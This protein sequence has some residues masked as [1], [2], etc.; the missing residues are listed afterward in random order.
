[1]NVGK[2]TDRDL[3]IGQLRNRT[4]S[5]T[6]PQVPSLIR[7]LD[8]YIPWWSSFNWS[9]PPQKPKLQSQNHDSAVRLRPAPI[10]QSSKGIRKMNKLHPL[11]QSVRVLRYKLDIRDYYQKGIPWPSLSKPLQSKKNARFTAS[12]RKVSQCQFTWHPLVPQ[13]K[14]VNDSNAQEVLERDPHTQITTTEMSDRA[15]N[16]S[17]RQALMAYIWA[18]RSFIGSTDLSS[19]MNPDFTVMIEDAFALMAQALNGVNDEEPSV[20]HSDNKENSDETSVYED[21]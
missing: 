15:Q 17:S 13:T 11:S 14:T 7:D 16:Q 18:R 3:N 12:R 2:I 9:S 21:S 10:T 5:V 19:D 1:M 20:T 8:S 6:A 4:I